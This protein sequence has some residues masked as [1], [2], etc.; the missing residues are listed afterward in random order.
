MSAIGYA[1]GFVL[2]LAALYAGSYVLVLRTFPPDD[3]A[4]QLEWG[5]TRTTYRINDE[6]VRQFFAPMLAFDKV[7]RPDFPGR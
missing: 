1:S 4:G 7:I 3:L 6:S 5:M 2:L